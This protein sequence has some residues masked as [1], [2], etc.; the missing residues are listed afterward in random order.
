MPLVH[1]WKHCAF[2]AM[3]RRRRS[4][5]IRTM[6]TRMHFERTRRA[7]GRYA[8]GFDHVERALAINPS[9]AVAYHFKG[10]LQI[11][12]AG[13]LK[14]V[15]AILRGIRLDPHRAASPLVRSQIAMSY[16]IEGDYE[17]TVAEAAA[18]DR[19][20]PRSSLWLPLAGCRVGPTGPKRRSSGRAG[21]GDSDR[22]R[23]VPPVCGPACTVDESG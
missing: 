9:C 20:P 2:Q 17:T 13:P 11:L 7:F 15:S 12:P 3:R 14:D 22:T 23:C 6:P 18:P 21:Q 4:N 8:S 1:C 5:L 10:W 16:Y 19:R